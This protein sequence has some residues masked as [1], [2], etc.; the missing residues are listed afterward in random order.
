MY[1]DDEDFLNSPG[2]RIYN[3]RNEEDYA[4]VSD[5]EFSGTE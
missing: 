2:I 1:S 4:F 3:D 5:N